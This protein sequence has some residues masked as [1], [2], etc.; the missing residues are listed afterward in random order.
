MS[1]ANFQTVMAHLIRFPDTSL[2]TV[3]KLV[4]DPALSDR[5][6]AQLSTMASDPMVRK[7]GSKMRYCRQRD[8]LTVMP[9]SAARIPTALVDELFHER[10]ENSTTST[11]F[12]ML[13]VHFLEFLLRDEIS[14]HKL[15]AERESIV[16]FLRYEHAK[17]WIVRQPLYV[18][19][20]TV[21]PHSKLAHGAFCVID[22]GHDIPAVDRARHQGESR[23]AE[24]APRAM[25]LLFFR[26]PMRPFYRMFQIDE[27]L[28]SFLRV[29]R[30][31]P[32]CP[33][34]LSLPACFADLVKIGLCRS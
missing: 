1:A 11:N 34:A 6:K 29:Q 20:P 21:S 5:E 19:D 10:F 13:G 14:L 22:V 25:K 9:M 31:S 33:T 15:S 8:A 17:A 18:A 30:D 16:D 3:L 4:G 32:T 27:S 24:P 23:L 28:A 26:T 7:F 2:T 12:V